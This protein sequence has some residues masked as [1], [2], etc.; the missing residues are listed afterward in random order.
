MSNYF[1]R[2]DLIYKVY[3]EKSISKAAQKLFISQPSLSVMIQRIEEEVGVPLFDRTS[4][5][6]SL[7]EAGKEYIKATEEI[8]H[9][10]KAF[11]NYLQACR[12][13][14]TGS[15]TIGS[16]QLLSSLV[17]P[18]YIGQFVAKYPKIHLNLV[19]DNSVV[20]E[21]MAIAGQLDL[22]LD[23]H[24][25]DRSIFEQH[26]IRTEHLLVAV[27]RDFACNAGLEKYQLS[28]EDIIEGRHLQQKTGFAPLHAF[29]GIP[30]VAMNR[31]NDTRRR[32]DEIWREAGI[33]PR[34]ILELD[35]L[36]T[37]YSFIRQGTAASIVSD[38]LVQY[39]RPGQDAVVFYPLK[40]QHAVRELYLS[41]KRN[42]YYSKA[43]E[44]FAK[45]FE[46]FKTGGDA[47]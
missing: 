5:P 17:L 9:T 2:K 45:L 28:G 42:R 1:S 38:T 23:N 21:N 29:A 43:M 47:S 32:S 46:S 24:P 11:E 18:E 36:V 26:I 41:Y 37:L 12:N 14:E 25:L 13:L 40:S 16:N 6:I 3:Q 19:D 30:Y 31:Q 8:M 20:L 27:P 15:L 22:V 10:E 4:K 7:T 33:K 34:S 35:R 39:L 44:A